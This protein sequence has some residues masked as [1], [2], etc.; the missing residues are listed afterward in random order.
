MILAGILKVRRAGLA[1]PMYVIYYSHGGSGMCV[2]TDLIIM[3]PTGTV[4]N[5][6][7]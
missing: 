2:G 3:A 5:P 1:H 6:L 4:A 7:P